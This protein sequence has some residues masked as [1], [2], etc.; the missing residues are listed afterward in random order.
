VGEKNNTKREIITRVTAGVIVAAVISVTTF[1]VGKVYAHE[2][3]LA[4]LRSQY[5]F[6]AT[7]LN[8]IEQRL[9][10]LYEILGRGR[11]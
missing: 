10:K 4:Q 3:E 5:E 11:P 2:R 1:L 7:S 8:R 9:D 6:I